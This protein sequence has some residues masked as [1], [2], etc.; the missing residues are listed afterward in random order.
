MKNKKIYIIIGIVA[1]V[2]IGYMLLRSNS[3]TAQQTPVENSGVVGTKVGDTAPEFST[4]TST[5]QEIQLSDF[6]GKI[7]VITSTA[8]WCSTCIVEAK[9]FVP[10]YTTIDSDEV[11]F[12]TVSI[13]PSEGDA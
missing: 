7:L 1:V 12:L 6:A 8:T 11:E 4:V 5:G 3:S 10:V 9:N 13:D 2:I